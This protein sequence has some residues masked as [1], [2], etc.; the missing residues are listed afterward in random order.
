MQSV[1]TGFTLLRQSMLTRVH[2][3]SRKIARIPIA[4]LERYDGDDHRQEASIISWP[5]G[6]L[7]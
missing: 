3:Y 5:G 1:D 7:A 6:P 2:D 4:Q